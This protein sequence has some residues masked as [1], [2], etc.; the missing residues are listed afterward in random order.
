M[1]ILKGLLSLLL[2]LCL[3]MPMGASIVAQSAGDGSAKIGGTGSDDTTPAPSEAPEETGSHDDFDA[4]EAK[5]HLLALNSVEEVNEYISS[6]T[7]EQVAALLSV[8]NDEEIRS[9]ADRLNVDLDEVV[10]TPA[11]NFTEVGPLMPPVQITENGQAFLLEQAAE[12]ENGLIL[13]KTAVY[14]EESG[15]YKITLEAYTTGTVTSGEQAIPTDIVLVLDE[16]GSMADS[17]YQYTK[18]YQ[19]NTNQDYYVKQD[20]SFVRVSWCDGGLFGTHDDGWYSGAHFILHWGTRY[21][22]MT[23]ENDTTF[24]HV[25]FYTRSETQISK[26]QALMDAATAFVNQVY[27]EAVTNSVDHRVAVVGF[28]GDGQSSIKIGLV[29]DIRNNRGTN[30]TSGTVL[31]AVNHL[32]ANGGTYIEDGMTNAKNVFDTAASTTSTTRNRI[33]IVFTDGIPGSGTWNNTTINNSANPAI[34]TSNTLKNTYGAT[35]YTIGM[36][37]DADPSLEISDNSDD[38]ARTNKFLHYLSSNYPNATSMSNGGS[39]SNAGYYLSASDTAS[40]T[41]I[42]RKISENISTPTISLGTETVVKDVVTQYFNVPAQGDIKLYTVDY[43]GT[44]FNDANRVPA[45]GVTA[46]VSGDTIS[47]TG[48]DYN[49]NFVSSEQ[50]DGTYGKKLII[51]FTVTPKDGFLG[52]NDVPTNGGSSGVYPDSNTSTAIEN[53]PVPTVNVPIKPVVV[54]PE[55]KNVYL[56]GGLTAAQLKNGATV[57]CGSVSLDLSDSDEVVNY[58]LEEWQNEYVNITVAVTDAAGNEIAVDG[59]GNLSNDTTYTITVTVAPKTDS[60]EEYHATPQSGSDSGNINVF[61]P[62]LTFADSEVWY[63]AE[64]SGYSENYIGSAWKHGETPAGDRMIGDAPR[65]VPNYTAPDGKIVENHIAV[66]DDIP[67]NVAVKIGDVDITEYVTFEHSACGHENCGFNPDNC[68]FMLHANTC[69]LTITKALQG[70]DNPRDAGQSFIFTVNYDGIENGNG[71]VIIPSAV[72]KVVISGE[73]MINGK[74]SR[75]IVGLPVGSYTVSEDT[76][77]SWRYELTTAEAD[78]TAELSAA[79]PNAAVTMTNRLKNEQWLGFETAAKNVFN[80]NGTPEYTPAP[81]V[82]PGKEGFVVEETD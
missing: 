57:T 8:L 78:R 77:W 11:V 21:E 24:G 52:G 16:S 6:L 15:G 18:V 45:T 10:Y 5:A 25:Q 55:D 66:P 63:G 67:V 43:N 80:S 76:D 59:L 62:V 1:K 58:G 13:N 19:L 34:S 70:I 68:E 9:L 39:G 35:V 33:V 22:P 51:E 28:S 79:T 27:D 37:D 72:Y 41:A 3:I 23:S 44:A 73:D 42:F 30:D 61:K 4:E 50:H 56:L 48:F 46:T 32:S 7:E 65:L 74:P 75:T 49:A 2:C 14:D 29:D 36:L 26:T 71:T 40:L 82:I 64:F 47:V 54:T 38:A 81:A 17:M 12:E 60:A 20:D 69:S 53:F 31:Y